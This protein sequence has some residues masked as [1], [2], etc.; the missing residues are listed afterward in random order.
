MDKIKEAIL[1]VALGYSLEEVTEEYDA[2]DG[3]LRLV[4]R[5]ETKK[6]IP[7]DLKAAKLLIDERDYS[8][9]SDEQLEEEKRRLIK[10]L[11]ASGGLSSE[12]GKKNMNIKEKL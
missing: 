3:E 6:D 7:P 9:L 11:V 4:K 1:K 8:A 2:K 12:Y 5:K 10:E